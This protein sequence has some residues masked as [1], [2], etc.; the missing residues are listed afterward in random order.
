MKKIL[1]ILIFI[2]ALVTSAYGSG[3]SPVSGGKVDLATGTSGSLPYTS[4]SGVP[5]FVT[6]P[7]WT[8]VPFNAADF[9]GSGSMTWT[10]YG[11][12]IQ[13]FS[14][15]ISGKTMTVNF[16]IMSTTVGGS[17]DTQ[18]MIKIPA[19]KVAASP[20]NNMMPLLAGD[21][22]TTMSL[23]MMAV[24]GT[25]QYIYLYKSGVIS[26]T[27]SASTVNTGVAGSITFQ[28]Q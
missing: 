24:F 5:N 25:N 4:V 10:V 20:G 6:S 21:N 27:W 22:T 11:G 9:T 19:G 8:A 7:T 14:Y 12:S 17:L 1:W 28:I 23:G 26:A 16:R 3:L 18:L 15:T 2:L 13:D